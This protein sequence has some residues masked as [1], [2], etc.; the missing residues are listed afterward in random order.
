VAK[1]GLGNQLKVPKLEIGKFFLGRPGS[2]ENIF[3][4]FE[5][6]LDGKGVRQYILR[7]QY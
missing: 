1:R 2:L 5:K 7:L 3:I 4:R 6:S